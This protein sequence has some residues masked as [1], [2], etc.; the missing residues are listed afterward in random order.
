MR[1]DQTYFPDK[2]VL[3]CDNRPAFSKSQN[4]PRSQL[5]LPHHRAVSD[6]VQVFIRCVLKFSGLFIKDTLEKSVISIRNR[7]FFMFKIISSF[8]LSSS[9]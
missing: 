3:S 1:S 4:R 8:Q 6:R 5:K 7:S 2:T 9:D